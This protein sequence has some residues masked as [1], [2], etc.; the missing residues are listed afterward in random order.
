MNSKTN[1]QSF[2]QS[3]SQGGL[4]K[5]IIAIGCTGVLVLVIVIIILGG[6]LYINGEAA[7]QSE[8]FF[9][10]PMNNERVTAGEPISIRVLARDEKKISKI[11]VWDADTLIISESSTLPGGSNPFPLI[12]TWNP[13]AGS[14]TLIARAVNSRN[15]TSQAS[16]TIEAMAADDPDSDGVAGTLDLCPE[17]PGSSGAAGCP[18][19][20]MDGIADVSDACPDEA[21]LPESGCPA[22]SEGDRDGDGTLDAEDICPDE[23]GSPM[24]DGCPDAD[25]DGVADAED[26]CPDEAGIGEDGCPIPGDADG[27]TVP[28]AEDACPHVWGLPET[29]GC[30]DA[31]GD[32]V[33]D[34]EDPCP[35]EPG[36]AG[37]CPDA[38]GIEPPGGGDDG[39]DGGDDEGVEGSEGGVFPDMGAD[40]AIDLVRVEALTFSVTQ[41]YDEIYCYAGVVEGDMERYGPFDSLGAHAWDIVEYMGGENT[42]TLGVV[43]GEPLRLRVSCEGTRGMSESYDLGSFTRTYDS[44]SWDGH[45]IEELSGATAPERGDPGH[46]FRM[47]FR[48]CHR[49]CEDSEFPPPILRQFD[50]GAIWWTIHYLG[51]DWTGDRSDIDGYRLYVNGHF[52]ETIHNPHASRLNLHAYMPDCGERNV[53][54]LTAYRMDGFLRRESPPSNGVAMVGD[55]CPRRVKVTFLDL[56]TS[57]LDTRFGD[58]RGIGPIS[59][60]LWASGTESE[61]LEFD[62]GRCWSFLWVWNCEGYDIDNGRYSIS[63]IFD[64]ILRMGASCLGGGCPTAIAPE[65]NYVIVELG[66]GDNLTFGG[67]LWDE[68]AYGS[69]H[70]LFRMNRTISAEEPLPAE[71]ALEENNSHGNFTLRVRIEEVD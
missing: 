11:E 52:R 47:T 63:G 37:G 58:M 43:V 50:E 27:D 41:D 14:H 25:S 33:I 44:S 9:R 36:G 38:G 16:V 39:G 71:Y 53:Y 60:S 29:D 5:G 42:R 2:T 32:G 65:V 18:D 56:T 45:V 51:W 62:G 68:E 10:S 15:E 61:M 49:T 28:D 59:G 20:D 31:D 26:T 40:E 46:S 57:G 23:P 66:E 13:T 8:I 21:G 30:P 3:L 12:T 70:R 1:P 34:S 69:D 17:E 7:S 64:E 24:A 55:R 54:T 22:P 67:S 35:A 4:G 48:L 19:R 6:Y